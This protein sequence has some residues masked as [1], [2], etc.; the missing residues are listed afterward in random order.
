M[1]PF[2]PE[3]F[4]SVFVSYNNA[5]WP[6]QIGAYLLGC[7]AIV[8]LLWRTSHGDRVTAG[9]LALMWLWTGIAYHWVFFSTINQA[10]Y[11]FGTLFM[12]EGCSLLYLGAYHDRLRFGLGRGSAGPLGAALVI[13][14]AVIYPLIGLSTGHRYPELPMFGLTPC[15]VT[16][17]TFGMLL[18]TRHPISRRLLIIPAIW[19]LIGGSAAVLLRVP[20]DWLLLASIVAVPV[21]ILRDRAIQRGPASGTA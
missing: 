16:I 12:I 9:I 4:T 11:V 5:I 17:F 20:Q 6:A 18:L 14:A 10:A 13:Y 21:I 2:T 3:Q 19:S 1:L 7:W 15:P 8:P